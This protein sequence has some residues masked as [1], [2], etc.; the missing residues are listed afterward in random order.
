MNF[1]VSQKSRVFLRNLVVS[2]V[3]FIF[4]GLSLVPAAA[5][6]TTPSPTAQNN[7]TQ[8]TPPTAPS[9]QQTVTTPTGPETGRVL[10]FP[11]PLDP[12]GDIGG[13]IADA[14]INAFK[15]AIGDILKTIVLWT[16]RIVA[17]LFG[18]AFDKLGKLCN[19][20][21]LLGAF[22]ETPTQASASTQTGGQGFN[23]FM[24]LDLAYSGM[25][26]SIPGNTTSTYLADTFKTNILGVSTVHAQGSG[27][28]DLGDVIESVWAKMRDLAIIFMVIA[29]VVIGFMVMLRRR[30]DP[31]T[32]VTATNS[33][34]RFAI[35]LVLIIFSFAISGFFI[36]LIHVT[37]SLVQNYF[38][39]VL[40][41]ATKALSTVSGLLGGELIWY[42]FFAAFSVG[43]LFNWGPI[44]CFGALSFFLLGPAGPAATFALL[45]F[46]LGIEILVRLTLF[47]VGIYIFWILLKN[48]AFMVIFTIFS[49]FFFLL[50]AVPGFE[51]VT[52]N[53]FKRMFATMLSFPLI[54]FFLYLSLYLL[55]QSNPVFQVT[56][57]VPHAP[58]PLQ[59]NILNINY[60]LALGILF[61][62]TKV[63]KFIEKIFKIDDVDVRGGLGASSLVAPVAVPA[64]AAIKLNKVAGPA[65]ALTSSMVA[66]GGV[67][68]KLASPFHNTMRSFSGQSNPFDAT[69]DPSKTYIRSAQEI[70]DK[71]FNV[72]DATGRVAREGHDA[73]RIAQRA[74]VEDYKLKN[75]GAS[76]DDAKRAYHANYQGTN[77]TL[78]NPTRS[79]QDTLEQ[80]VEDLND[81][82]TKLQ[83]AGWTPDNI[84]KE[85]KEYVLA[86]QDLTKRKV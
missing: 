14:L 2:L 63:P 40:G 21:A 15:V 16:F 36:D 84:K 50:G 67:M 82:R 20:K 76:D 31:R 79:A 52:G 51:G 83:G 10:D 53:W 29:L 77:P 19:G 32:V 70:R 42:P 66:R 37:V 9:S 27:T 68:G 71:A 45:V 6:Q 7:L 26:Q 72:K 55:M 69:G 24:G 74:F 33:L 41:P 86:N 85:L 78:V 23:L 62:A 17:E 80:G 57:G 28:S 35:A 13:K 8:T 49:P 18:F 11:N 34:P 75:I 12:L 54:L 61:F 73:A 43:S 60:L 5:A 25:L 56:K 64:G 38:G 1:F 22:G 81:Y 46:I 39:D 48:Y 30:L 3:L 4:S 58:P 59:S 65:T 44:L 47:I